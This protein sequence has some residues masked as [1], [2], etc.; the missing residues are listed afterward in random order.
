MTVEFPPELVEQ[1]AAR[2][3]ELVEVRDDDRWMNAREAADYLAVPVS[4]IHKLTAEPDPRRPIPFEQDVA[5][6]KLYFKR[7][8]LD[9]WRE[10][11]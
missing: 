3:A 2:A 5:G 1:I 10:G 6:G 11:H 9:R 4:T 7:S 8:A